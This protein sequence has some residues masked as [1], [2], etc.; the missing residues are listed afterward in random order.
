MR[1]YSTHVLNP[2]SVGLHSAA[3]TAML[4]L[5]LGMQKFPHLNYIPAL[6]TSLC[7]TSILPAPSPEHRRNQADAERSSTLLHHMVMALITKG[8]T[9][10]SLQRGLTWCWLI[11]CLALCSLTALPVVPAPM[12]GM[13]TGAAS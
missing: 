4:P 9:H 8:S 11:L 3:P 7:P 13:T 2:C 1:V 10:H 12:V 5:L 6:P